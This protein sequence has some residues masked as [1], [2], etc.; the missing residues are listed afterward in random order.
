MTN[1]IAE[2]TRSILAGYDA[3]DPRPTGALLRELW[4]ESEPKSI[5]VIKAEQRQAQETSGT[6][7]PVLRC[8]GKEL[9]KAARERPAGLLP[10]A[11]LL[12][13]EFGR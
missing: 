1:E 10:L 8:V 13:D 11:L 3:A 5:D 2:R 7:V 9:A 4:L 12:W 6:P